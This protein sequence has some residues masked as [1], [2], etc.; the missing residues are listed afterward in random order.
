MDQNLQAPQEQSVP[1]PQGVAMQQPLQMQP[2]YPGYGYS[3]PPQQP[4]SKYTMRW[5]GTQMVYILC[6]A[7]G[8]SLVAA[9]I[10]T[11]ASGRAGDTLDRSSYELI[12][13]SVW[14]CFAIVSLSLLSLMLVEI[15]FRKNITFFQY[16]LI[17]LAIT[18]FYLMLLAFA[19]QMSFALAYIVVSLMIIGLIAT[20][21]RGITTIN[22]AVVLTVTA[23]AVEYTA[24]FILLMLGNAAL[25]VGSLILFTILAAAMFL[26]LHLRVENQEIVLK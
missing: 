9:W 25:L 22:K 21:I 6:I 5:L 10:D 23:L 2:G 17:G 19:E 11:I 20:F 24:M 8:L 1:R 4:T 12:S 13:Q 7:L 3:C 26:T 18:L 14:Y 16:I 15:V